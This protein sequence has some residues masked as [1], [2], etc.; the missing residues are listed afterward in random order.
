M[1]GAGRRVEP[2]IKSDL[3]SGNLKKSFDKTASGSPLAVFFLA[4]LVALAAGPTHGETG[5]P[6]GADAPAV[7]ALR[8][9]P[10]S[11]LEAALPDDPFEEVWRR[12]VGEKAEVCWEQNDCGEQTGDPATDRERQMPLCGEVW[13]KLPSGETAGVLVGLGTADAAS[14]GRPVVR[15]AYLRD[16]AR[17]EDFQRVG[18]LLDRIR[19]LSAP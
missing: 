10:A 16:G 15:S 14:A 11:V 3:R 9:L 17:H 7:L 12:T 5:C 18:E 1:I 19:R 2:P 13:T 6:P 4:S 8:A